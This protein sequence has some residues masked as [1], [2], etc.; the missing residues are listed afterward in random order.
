MAFRTNPPVQSDTAKTAADSVSV[1]T[2]SATVVAAN[3]DRVSVTICNDHATQVLYLALGAT[4]VV[5][6]GIR[7]NAAGGQVTIT[8]Y[9]GIITGVATGTATVAAFSEV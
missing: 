6:K 4:A 3:P 9:T 7:V 5:N 8:A 2:S 1:G